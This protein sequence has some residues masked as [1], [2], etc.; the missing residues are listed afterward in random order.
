MKPSKSC[1]NDPENYMPSLSVNNANESVIKSNVKTLCESI[2]CAPMTHVESPSQSSP[3]LS[4]NLSVIRKNIHSSRSLEVTETKRPESEPLP[5]KR[6]LLELVDCN[7]NHRFP[8]ARSAER[9]A[10]N[11]VSSSSLLSSDLLN[12][13]PNLDKP[14]CF[15]EEPTPASDKPLNTIVDGCDSS[16]L[17][18][19]SAAEHKHSTPTAAALNVSNNAKI[20]TP[21]ENKIA[22]S[23][24]PKVGDNKIVKANFDLNRTTFNKEASPVEEYP[25]PS[26]QSLINNKVVQNKPPLSPLPNHRNEGE[27]P[28]IKKTNESKFETCIDE[29]QDIL[30]KACHAVGLDGELMNISDA[31]EE[32]FTPVFD[33]NQHFPIQTYTSCGIET[34]KSQAKNRVPS[35]SSVKKQTQAGAQIL[36][37]NFHHGQTIRGRAPDISDKN[38]LYHYPY[39]VPYINPP[40][41]VPKTLTNSSE[42][43]YKNQAY[44]SAHPYYN[45]RY[46]PVTM[47]NDPRNYSQLTNQQRPHYY[48]SSGFPT[49][50]KQVYP[51]YRYPTKQLVHSYY[52][53]VPTT[54]NSHFTSCRYD[55]TIYP[56]TFNS[57]RLTNSEQY[58]ITPSFLPQDK[59]L[60]NHRGYYPPMHS[61]HHPTKSTL[62]PSL[63]THPY[64]AQK[65]EYSPVRSP[66]SSIRYN[67]ARTTSLPE[68]PTNVSKN[69][70]SKIERVMER[71]Y[72]KAEEPVKYSAISGQIQDKDLFYDQNWIYSQDVSDNQTVSNYYNKLTISKDINKQRPY[73]SEKARQYSYPPFYCNEWKVPTSISS[74]ENDKNNSKLANTK[75]LPEVNTK[76]LTNQNVESNNSQ[77]TYCEQNKMYQQ[78]M[79]KNNEYKQTNLAYNPPELPHF[80]SN[81][82]YPQNNQFL[83][84][85]QNASQVEI[86]HSKLRDNLPHLNEEMSENQSSSSAVVLTNLIP[87][88][89]TH[90]SNV[91]F[92]TATFTSCSHSKPNVNNMHP[93]NNST[94]NIKKSYSGA[95]Q[96]TYTK[97]H[98]PPN[99]PIK[100]NLNNHL[101]SSNII[102]PGR[103]GEK[104][105]SNEYQISSN[106][107]SASSSNPITYDNHTSCNLPRIAASTS[108]R[109]PSPTQNSTNIKIFPSNAPSS[110]AI[111]EEL[112]K[113]K[114]NENSYNQ[115]LHVNKQTP[116]YNVQLPI[117]STPIPVSSSSTPKETNALSETEGKMQALS[118]SSQITIG[119]FI[120]NKGYAT[121]VDEEESNSE[122]SR[123]KQKLLPVIDHLL[124]IPEA[125]SLRPLRNCPD[126][127][128][129]HLVRL[130]GGKDANS[131]AK[132]CYLRMK[133][134]FVSLVRFLFKPH[135]LNAWGW[136]KARPEEILDELLSTSEQGS[137][138]IVV[139][140]VVL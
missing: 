138:Y 123:F 11:S 63:S 79:Y 33:Y 95:K 18:H 107:T 61:H 71:E 67:N 3:P 57:Q 82:Y 42:K 8:I 125:A 96:R 78:Q 6:R 16:N 74:P 133:E 75:T 17:I 58:T 7:D 76:N 36:K 29:F 105:T 53:N 72:L 127:L 108:K 84:P 32:T 92:S 90:S 52:P 34:T 80:N 113:Q 136:D 19:S 10:A 48:S 40:S 117:D 24:S 137:Y 89:H 2:P 83:Y 41:L 45:Y 5:K 35:Y 68:M 60:S 81:N 13:S 135:L 130:W 132:D 121:F 26:S 20:V 120:L 118:P 73:I 14:K 69:L 59:M 116:S 103:L 31:P 25:P 93:D 87:S 126:E 44:S 85:N 55:S 23:S 101:V 47:G 38:V 128:L 46:P 54:E 131:T 140:V 124:S 28:N 111:S 114:M 106:F 115:V 65:I 139:V 109:E 99:P 100:E 134:N 56:S 129:G 86:N 88:T 39:R 9:E 43:A 15:R 50:T 112:L 21:D 91:P 62:G 30:A 77:G 1:T 98:C 51:Y 102:S 27:E 37:G 22:A 64:P 97:S 94:S 66:M 110:E 49:N 104:V 4:R 12:G 70:G 122:F 119:P